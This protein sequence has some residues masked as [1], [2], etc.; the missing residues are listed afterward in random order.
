[1]RYILELHARKAPPDHRSTPENR[2]LAGVEAIEPA[3]KKRLDACWR[4]ERDVRRFI[5]QSE[6]LLGE[7]RIAP[8]VVDDL[9]M[10][11]RVD[12]LA[13]ELLD[14]RADRFGGKRFEMDEEPCR[15]RAAPPWPFLQE[16][17]ACEAE[18]ENR[19]LGPFA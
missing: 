15:S 13:G 18:N 6:E 16:L 19:S 8:C 7:E 4:V 12:R 3:G 9:L 1:M 5:R 10:Y 11:L 2:Q 14:Q 17:S